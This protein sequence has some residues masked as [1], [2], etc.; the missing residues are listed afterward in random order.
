MARV[1]NQ[2]ERYKDMVDFLEEIY[3][4]NSGEVIINYTSLL[5]V[6]FINF[7]SSLRSYWKTELR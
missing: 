3:Q 1:A 5:K 7:I 4:D 2:S 6:E